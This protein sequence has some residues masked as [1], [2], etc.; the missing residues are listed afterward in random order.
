MRAR[1]ER[2]REIQLAETLS[3]VNKRLAALLENGAVTLDEICQN[4]GWLA[5]TGRAA[6]A[7]LRKTGMKV[8]SQKIDGQTGYR[9]ETQ[10]DATDRLWNGISRKVALFYQRRAAVLATA[11]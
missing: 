9:L 6:I 5:H 4:F 3:P 8:V 7:R 2:S 11:A 10:N 1:N